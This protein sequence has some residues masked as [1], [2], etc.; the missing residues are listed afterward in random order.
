MTRKKVTLAYITNVS[1][2]KAS[3]KK[4]KKG[5]IK[6]AQSILARLRKLSNMDQ[7]RKMGNQRSFTR[8]RNKKAT[9]LH[10]HLQK[11]NNCRELEAFMFRCITGQVSIDDLNLPDVWKWDGSSTNAQ[12]DQGQDGIL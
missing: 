5:L 9:E 3:Y 10:R 4:G 1:E 7:S 2:R 11:E 8:Q 6:K 12:G